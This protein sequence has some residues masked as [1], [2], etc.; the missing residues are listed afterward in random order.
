MKQVSNKSLL[1]TLLAI[2]LF[3]ACSK[4][5]SFETGAAGAVAA[6]TLKDTLGACQEIAIIRAENLLLTILTHAFHSP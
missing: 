3:V 4:E 2:I 5:L 6:G 1:S